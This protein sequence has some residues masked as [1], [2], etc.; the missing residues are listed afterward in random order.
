MVQKHNRKTNMLIVECMVNIVDGMG[1][2]MW[3]LFHGRSLDISHLIRLELCIYQSACSPLSPWPQTLDITARLSAC[4]HLTTLDV[5][6]IWKHTYPMWHPQRSYAWYCMTAVSVVKLS[7]YSV[8]CISTI[9]LICLLVDIYFSFRL[10][11]RSWVM[12]PWSWQSMYFCEILFLSFL[13]Q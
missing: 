10:V 3:A 11:G 1:I 5:S 2:V 9:S 6:C 12:L 4:M 13:S 8:S 7:K